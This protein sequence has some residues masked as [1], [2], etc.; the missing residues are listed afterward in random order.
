MGALLN[1]K[2]AAADSLKGVACVPFDA[3]V[4]LTM[5]ISGGAKKIGITTK[6]APALARPQGVAP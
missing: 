2:V 5:L 6:S 1:R 3:E 4:T